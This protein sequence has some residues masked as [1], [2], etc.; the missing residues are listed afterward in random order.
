MDNNSLEQYDLEYELEGIERFNAR[1]IPEL[2]QTAPRRTRS[3]ASQ[4]TTRGFGHQLIRACPADTMT[5]Y[6][7]LFDFEALTRP[8]HISVNY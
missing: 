2:Y 6:E 4:H 3:L 7:T 5:R 1:A 8:C